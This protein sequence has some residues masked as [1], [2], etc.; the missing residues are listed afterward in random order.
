MEDLTM[1]AAAAIVLQYDAIERIAADSHHRARRQPKDVP[2]GVI[3]ALQD[4]V[5]IVRMVWSLDF[6]VRC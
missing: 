6:P 4:Q 5:G 1:P 3:R 2:P